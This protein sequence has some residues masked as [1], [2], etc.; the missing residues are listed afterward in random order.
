MNSNELHYYPFMLD[1]DNSNGTCSALDDTST[2]ICVL[3]KTGDV[4]LNV[5][6]IITRINESRTL[7][8]HISM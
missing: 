7:T 4:I 1:L 2:R 6:I 5:F 8:K 3:N